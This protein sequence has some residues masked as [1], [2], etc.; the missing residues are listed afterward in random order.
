MAYT[1]FIQNKNGN[2]LIGYSKFYNQKNGRKYIKI[3]ELLNAKIK[4]NNKNSN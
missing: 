4:S 3:V 2:N 1:T